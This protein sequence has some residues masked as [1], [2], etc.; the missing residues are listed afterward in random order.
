MP[1]TRQF[2][3]YTDGYYGTPV[4]ISR[5][6]RQYPFAGQ[7]NTTAALYDAV[8][9]VD[10]GLFTPTARGTVDPENAG[11]YLV[12]ESKP[13]I[14]DGDLALVRRT[15]AS[16]PAD[17]I[18]YTSRDLIKPPFTSTTF[19]GY[20]I[21]STAADTTAEVWSL[22]IACTS[23]PYVSGGTFTLTYKASTTGAL[24]YNASNATIQAALDA[25]ADAVTDAITFTVTNLLSTAGTIRVDRA[26]GSTVFSQSDWSLNIS[27]LT[28]SAIQADQAL[29]SNS[30][31]FYVSRA[32]TT[33]TKVGHGLSGG[34]EIRISG[35]S[36]LLTVASVVDADNFTITNPAANIPYAPTS[37][38]TYVRD[39]TPGT[40]R[41]QLKV[42][43]KFYL[44]GVTSGI[45]TA[46]DI[47][48]PA[49]AIDDTTFLTLVAEGA[50]GWQTYDAD[51][52]TRW[53][54]E[55][56]PIYRQRLFAINL[57]AV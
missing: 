41:L 16:A 12:A 42:T 56:S 51:A 53:P 4:R 29:G 6:P 35:G 47:P 1:T 24:A 21:T 30:A 27:S 11:F 26:T 13:E 3:R 25:L 7:G 17:V 19:G 48:V 39:Y 23:A 28:P 5:T 10:Q 44:P 43:D 8:Y 14:V 49:V 34:D 36:V 40:A 33:V 55:E 32:A 9:L 46:E 38:R 2:S 31:G 22:S 15:Y 54:T 37:Y 18:D 45:T 50:A 57:S 20:Y 52:L